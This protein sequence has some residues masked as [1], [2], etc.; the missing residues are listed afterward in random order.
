MSL[1][2]LSTLTLLNLACTAEE[3]AGGMGGGG[4]ANDINQPNTGSGQQGGDD[5][6]T[7]G[8]APAITGG[9]GIWNENAEG[10]WQILVSITYTDADN[11]IDG[12][13]VGLSAEVTGVMSPEQWFMI[14]GHE[15]I[16]DAEAGLV[17]VT[18][19]LEQVEANPDNG[20]VSLMVRLRD[21]NGN[22]STG[23]SI[24]PTSE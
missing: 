15:A 13:Q 8:S 4:I 11:D 18:I 3:E 17:D 2:A 7:Y 16:H 23:Y 24:T 21:A 6:G 14:D 12:G 9:E 20:G 19:L 5:T 22:E 10:Q 1:L